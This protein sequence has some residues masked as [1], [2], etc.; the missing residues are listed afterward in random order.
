L[1]KKIGGQPTVDLAPLA[2]RAMVECGN[3]LPFFF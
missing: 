1:K 3:D 2:E